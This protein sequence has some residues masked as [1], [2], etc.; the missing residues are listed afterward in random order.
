MRG[1]KEFNIA[2][3]ITAATPI[4]Q[5]GALDFGTVNKDN[6]KSLTVTFTTP[7]TAVPNVSVTFLS[8]VTAGGF[9]KNTIAV[10]SVSKTQAQ[11]RAFNGDDGGA[12][13]PDAY[14]IAWGK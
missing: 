14:W 4:F 13:Q 10:E 8:T 3:Q 1:S 7:F 11:F 2:S 12:R 6:S 9:G 5:M